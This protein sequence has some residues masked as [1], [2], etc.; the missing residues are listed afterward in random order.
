MPQDSL[1]SVVYR[2]LVHCDDP[3][4]VVENETIRKSKIYPKKLE[5]KTNTRRSRKGSNSSLVYKEERNERVFSEGTSEELQAPPSFQLLEV[6]RGAQNL[7]QMI[8]S[9]SNGT[10]IDGQ[11]EDIAKDLLRG[12]LDLQESLIMLCKMQE[13]SKFMSRLKKKHELQSELLDEV[14]VERVDS[15]RFG[16]KNYHRSLQNSRLS[17]GGSSRNCT[18]ELKKVI[19]ESLS[20]QNLLPIPSDEENFSLDQMKFDSVSDIPST[21]S[22]Q[23]SVVLSNDFASFGSSVSSTTRQKKAKSPSVIAK[24]MGLEE[25]PS[26]SIPSLPKQS[27]NERNSNQRRPI[28]DIEIPKARKP[29]F[30]NRDSDSER[31]TLE[32][33]IETMQFKGLLQSKSHDERLNFGSH[34]P[35]KSFPKHMLDDEMP[36]IV[37]IKPLHFPSREVKRF[38]QEEGTSYY[39][40]MSKKMEAREDPSSQRFIQDEVAVEPKVILSKMEAKEEP[41]SNVI[42]QDEEV[43]DPKNLSLKLEVK[44]ESPARRLI[45]EDG[46][47]MSTQIVRKQRPKELKTMETSTTNKMKAS[48]SQHHKPEKMEKTNNKVG[49]MQKTLPNRRKL[50]EKETA[51]ASTAARSLDQVKATSTKSR[52]LENGSIISR[53][54][55]HL[56]QSTTKNPISRRTIKPTLQNAIDQTK[57]SRTRKEKPVRDSLLDTSITDTLQCKDGIKEIHPADKMSSVSSETSTLFDDQ[58][59]T[60]KGMEAAKVHMEDHKEEDQTA[61]CEVPPQTSQHVSGIDSSE[62]A[63]QL[64]DHKIEFPSKEINLKRLFLSS[65]SFLSSAEELFDLNVNQPIILQ[66]TLVQDIGMINTRLYFDCATELMEHKSRWNSRVL[67]PLIRTRL[68]NPGTNISLDGLVEEVCNEIE[69]SRSYS[70]IDGDNGVPV[71]N[72]FK[73]LENDLKRKEM[74]GNGGWDLGWMNGF[75]VNEADQVVG[76]MEKKVLSELIDEFIIDLVF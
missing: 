65:P 53:D 19:R 56:Q 63:K 1:K 18:E 39:K 5:R 14:G 8:D 40:E 31:T 36:P 44:E 11:S 27:D 33:I 71:D 48:V 69:I 13:A 12:A 23:S 17:I 57:Q 21:S 55:M 72:L 52:K 68:A 73:M 41:V 3:N 75:S 37:I 54:H 4:G 6:S 29:Y 74:L 20:R 26:E 42:T 60:N 67:H 34:H 66:T 32:E 38:I 59:P 58:Q 2:S 62:E 7:N 28:S 47:L 61:L 70:K 24:L 22:S 9:W 76:E 16:E 49:K 51:K 50:M 64:V 25:F 10:A 35:K 43:L 15:G 46:N 45:R 30:V